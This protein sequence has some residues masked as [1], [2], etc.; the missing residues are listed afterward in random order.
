M[1]PYNIRVGIIV[2]Y[3]D[4]DHDNILQCGRCRFVEF[5]MRF[6][7]AVYTWHNIP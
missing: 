4:S 1:Y 7:R 3:I 5:K 2:H 6:V